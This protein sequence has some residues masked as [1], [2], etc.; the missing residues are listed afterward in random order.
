MAVAEGSRQKSGYQACSKIQRRQTAERRLM[1]GSGQQIS[2][3]DKP[4]AANCRQEAARSNMQ[5]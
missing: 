2:V 3:G 1:A 5:E 4:A